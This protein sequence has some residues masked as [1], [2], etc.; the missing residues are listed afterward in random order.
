MKTHF[1]H[2]EGSLTDIKSCTH[3]N[4]QFMG[5]KMGLWW[6]LPIS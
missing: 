2:K 1:T 4:P 6:D 3:G 5:W